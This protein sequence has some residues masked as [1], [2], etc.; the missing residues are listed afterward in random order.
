[1]LEDGL[2]GFAGEHVGECES[3]AVVG[4]FLFKSFM[5]NTILTLCRK[6][7]LKICG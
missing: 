4:K 1:M 7:L 2:G 5:K 6:L 3:I